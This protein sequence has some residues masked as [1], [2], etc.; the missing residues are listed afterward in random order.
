MVVQWNA[1]INMKVEFAY[2]LYIFVYCLKHS[3]CYDEDVWA[4]LHASYYS[5]RYLLP[6]NNL[7]NS[8]HQHLG[9]WEVITYSFA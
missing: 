7:G 1:Q 3:F 5:T 6:P 8:I 2:C 9:I 4:N